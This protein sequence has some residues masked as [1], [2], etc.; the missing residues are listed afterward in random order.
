MLGKGKGKSE[1]RREVDMIR[2]KEDLKAFQKMKREKYV[3]LEETVG[4]FLI[5]GGEKMV[6][7][8][9]FYSVEFIMGGGWPRNV[10]GRL[11]R[12][13]PVGKPNVDV[14]YDEGGGIWL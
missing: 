4:E 13:I 6:K 8:I 7:R 10:V 9:R 5:K 14:F 1:R 3:E 11:I 12:K 2:E